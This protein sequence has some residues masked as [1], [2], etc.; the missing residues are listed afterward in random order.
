MSS[1][2]L[3]YISLLGL[4][5]GTTLIAS[6]FSVGQFEPSTYVGLRLAMAAL[7]HIIFY[8]LFR[9]RY[10]WPTDRRLWLHASL[11]GVLG[12]AVPM[13]SIITS[14]QYLSSGL[15]STLMT[16]NPAFTV[17]FAHFLLTDEKLT[18]RKSAGILLALSGTLFLALRGESGLPNIGQANPLGYI[19]ILGAMVFGSGMTIYVRKYMQSYDS[20]DVATIRMIAASIVV[21]PL[22]VLFVG[23]DLQAVNGQG[24]FVLFY[25]ALIGTFGG[26]LL[27]VNNIKRFGATAAAM[28][29]YVIPVVASVGGV[30]VLG[31]QITAVMLIGM[32]LIVLGI[33]II[34]KKQP[35]L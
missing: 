23:F 30:F 5:W 20:F 10:K 29:A 35:R 2:A 9:Q 22:S 12:T 11:L 32:V 8:A 24:V 4:M 31:E 26:M 15:A 7:G 21:M 33:M 28:T 19:L 1:E 25:A 13:T 17:L 14:L 6:R 16:T 3:P 27:A 34:N 18:R